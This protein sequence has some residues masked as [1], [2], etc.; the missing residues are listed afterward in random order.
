MR[1][2]L[3]LMQKNLPQDTCGSVKMFGNAV[4]EAK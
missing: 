4:K 2:C 1:A 3:V